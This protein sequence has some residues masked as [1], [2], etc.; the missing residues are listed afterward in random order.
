MGPSNLGNDPRSQWLLQATHL[1]GPRLDASVYLRR[2]GTL[3]RPRVEAYTAA[4][5]TVNWRARP[6]WQ[7]SVGVRNAFDARHVEY[8]AGTFT[9]EIPRSAFVSVV[10]QPR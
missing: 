8:D 5:F 1:I 9:G 7:L 6:G 3:P 4:D 2:V 10:Y